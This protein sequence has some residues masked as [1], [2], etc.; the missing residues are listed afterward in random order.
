MIL[1]FHDSQQISHSAISTGLCTVLLNMEY[2]PKTAAVWRTLPE[3]RQKVSIPKKEG[4]NIKIADMW[5]QGAELL[6]F[7]CTCR[8]SLFRHLCP[9]PASWLPLEMGKTFRTVPSQG[10]DP[11]GTSGCCFVGCGGNKLIL[12]RWE[13]GSSGFSVLTFS[14]PTWLFLFYCKHLSEPKGWTDD[15]V[16]APS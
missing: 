7:P 4:W 12:S 8:A 5:L 10:P 16:S 14:P 6:P 2:Q 1:W 13:Q 11:S 15:G 9:T 3:P